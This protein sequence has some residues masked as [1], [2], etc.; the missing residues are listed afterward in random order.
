M[1]ANYLCLTRTAARRAAFA[2][3]HI[4]GGY[5]YCHLVAIP[6]GGRTLPA[7]SVRDADNVEIARVAFFK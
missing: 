1:M 7:F 6:H 2:V 3:A 4:R 5:V